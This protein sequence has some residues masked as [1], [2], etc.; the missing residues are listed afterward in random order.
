MLSEARW[1]SGLP[2]V[3]LTCSPNGS[4]TT[5]LGRQLNCHPN[6]DFSNGLL[7]RI[8]HR[9]GADILVCRE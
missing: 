7:A 4:D 3:I 9:G 2:E 6:I 1:S 5:M 8:S